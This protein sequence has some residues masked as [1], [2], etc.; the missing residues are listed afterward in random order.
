MSCYRNLD[1]IHDSPFYL[2]YVSDRADLVV[3]PETYS[4]LTL[5]AYRSS[6]SWNC[7]PPCSVITNQCDATH[8]N[9]LRYPGNTETRPTKGGPRQTLFSQF[10]ETSCLLRTLVCGKADEL[11]LQRVLSPSLQDHL[12]EGQFANVVPSLYYSGVRELA[13]QGVQC[14]CVNSDAQRD[15]TVFHDPTIIFIVAIPS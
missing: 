1:H 5:N 4:K 2:G 14:R 10:A 13:F 15:R 9:L 3:R 6:R 12:I 7:T 8:S 11:Q